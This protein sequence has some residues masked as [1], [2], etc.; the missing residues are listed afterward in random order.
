MRETLE[1]AT[2][3]APLTLALVYTTTATTA[4]TTNTT[5]NNFI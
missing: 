3:L 1:S 2:S 5:N 4:T